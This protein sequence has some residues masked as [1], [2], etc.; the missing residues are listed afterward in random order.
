MASYM[1]HFCAILLFPSVISRYMNFYE[2]DMN[3]YR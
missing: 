1:I 3:Y 2:L